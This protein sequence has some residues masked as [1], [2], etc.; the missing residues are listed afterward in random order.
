LFCFVFLEKQT[1]L[2]SSE[3]FLWEL[4]VEW[5]F[6]LQCLLSGSWCVTCGL[7]KCRFVV[8]LIEDMT[9]SMC[10]IKFVFKQ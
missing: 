6:S 5:M 3:L 8:R 9:L 7:F 10:K 2:L 4:F 1:E